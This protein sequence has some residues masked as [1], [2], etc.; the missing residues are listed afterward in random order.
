VSGQFEGSDVDLSTVN[1]EVGSAS[2]VEHAAELVAFT[3]AVMADDDAELARSRKALLAAIGPAAFVDTCAVIGAF[4]VVDRI[5]D[6]TGIP[7][8]AGLVQISQE[9]R[10][11]L[12]LARFASSANTPG[13]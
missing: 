2:G 4:N 8:D 9:V 3:E 12:D 11:D 10:A 1:G 13:A 7:L 5:A 6:S